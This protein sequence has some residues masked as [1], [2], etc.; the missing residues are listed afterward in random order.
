[1]GYPHTV[2]IEGRKIK[3]ALHN[4]LREWNTDHI[5]S[6]LSIS[7]M[8]APTMKQLKEKWANFASDH[9]RAA[10]RLLEFDKK[11]ANSAPS[12]AAFSGGGNAGVSRRGK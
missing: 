2:E 6:G 1:M 7:M 11:H 10:Q 4:H 3:L 9:P 8:S 5:E 12:P